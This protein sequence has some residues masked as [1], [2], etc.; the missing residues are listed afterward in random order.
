MFGGQVG[1]LFLEGNR[2]MS[3]DQVTQN[4]EDSKLYQIIHI[5]WVSSPTEMLTKRGVSQSILL[6]PL[7]PINREK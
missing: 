7:M 1:E 5:K 3:Q 2:L 4:K 6:L